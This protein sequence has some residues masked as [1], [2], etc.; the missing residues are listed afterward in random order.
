MEPVDGKLFQLFADA[1]AVGL[2]YVR[3]RREQNGYFRKHSDWPK[4]EW[5]ENGMPWISEESDGPLNY[6]DALSPVLFPELLSDAPPQFDLEQPSSPSWPILV[7]TL[8]LPA[9]CFGGR[10]AVC[11]KPR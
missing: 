6:A 4:L 1:T 10:I 3:R 7:R 11:S 5:R 2:E 9:I 8:A